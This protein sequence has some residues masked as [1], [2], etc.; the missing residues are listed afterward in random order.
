MAERPGMTHIPGTQ[1]RQAAVIAIALGTADEVLVWMNNTGAPVNIKQAGFI[2]DEAHTGAATNNMALQFKS[3]TAA[4]AAKKNITAVK[5]YASGT[6]M[7][8]FVKDALVVSTTAADVIVLDGESVTLDK[9]ENGTGL[10]LP[11]G[12][13]VLEFKYD[14]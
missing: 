7:T 6:D 10:G 2:P 3:K 8:K 11:A 4:G 1:E 12:L 14:N 5:T 9:T 13:A